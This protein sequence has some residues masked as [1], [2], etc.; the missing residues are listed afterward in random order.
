MGKNSW[1]DRMKFSLNGILVFYLD[2]PTRSWLPLDHFGSLIH[3]LGNIVGTKRLWNVWII[4]FFVCS[5][6]FENI[7]LVIDLVGYFNIGF[8]ILWNIMLIVLFVYSLLLWNDVGSWILWIV[9]L[10]L[11]FSNL[12]IAP[13]I[14]LSGMSWTTEQQKV[15]LRVSNQQIS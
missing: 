14:R 4:V 13:Q 6:L 9:K 15:L 12:F 5:L 3:A 1:W 10:I 8:L 11:I 2:C 7:K